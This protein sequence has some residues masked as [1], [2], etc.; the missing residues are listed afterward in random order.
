MNL[1]KRFTTIAL[2]DNILEKKYIG[3]DEFGIFTKCWAHFLSGNAESNLS[4]T[5]LHSLDQN[6][7]Y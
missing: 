1:I 2:V 5:Q 3:G 7:P 4:L 6:N